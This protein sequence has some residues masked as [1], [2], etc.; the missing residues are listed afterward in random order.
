MML[1]STASAKMTKCRTALAEHI[2][3]LNP[4]TK[5]ICLDRFPMPCLND[6]TPSVYFLQPN[7]WAL[8]L[9]N[10]HSHSQPSH[11]QYE[12][13][14]PK[15]ECHRIF[16]NEIHP[17][18]EHQNKDSACR[19]RMQ[20]SYDTIPLSTKKTT[21]NPVTMTR[22][23]HLTDSPLIIPDSLSRHISD[24][25]RCLL[26]RNSSTIL[27]MSQS[28]I[29]IDIDDVIVTYSLRN[30]RPDNRVTLRRLLDL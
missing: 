28:A 9:E 15:S 30:P 16:L 1:Q 3:C 11:F 22:M 8:Q 12:A 10:C 4:L 13:R 20:L 17:L 25:S 14:S 24:I 6:L 7:H 21:G 18:A 26:A 27:M 23:H 2:I 5:S 29:S 19:V